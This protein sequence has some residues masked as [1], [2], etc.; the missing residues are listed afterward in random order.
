M[1]VINFIYVFMFAMITEFLRL[2][3]FHISK[4]IKRNKYTPSVSKP[5]APT[6]KVDPAVE[7]NTTDICAKSESVKELL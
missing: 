6:K 4:I 5:P 1:L 7:L 3:F 2:K